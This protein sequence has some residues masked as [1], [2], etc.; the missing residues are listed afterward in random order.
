MNDHE[1]AAR[2]MDRRADDRA[3]MLN[4]MVGLNGYTIS[5]GVICEELNGEGYAAVPFAA[6][7]GAVGGQME[8]G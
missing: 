5:S 1:D 3:A 4:L 2:M 6:E 7:A 8:I